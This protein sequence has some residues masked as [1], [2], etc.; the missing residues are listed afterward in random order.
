MKKTVIKIHGAHRAKL[1]QKKNITPYKTRKIGER[2]NTTIKT[3]QKKTHP[4]VHAQTMLKGNI[5]KAT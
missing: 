2:P 1:A 3:A 5:H 4:A